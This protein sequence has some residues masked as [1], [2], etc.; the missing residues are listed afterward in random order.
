MEVQSAIP[1]LDEM[2]RLVIPKRMRRALRWQGGDPIMLSMASR[3]SLLLHRY[4]QMQALRAVASGYADAFFVTY[5]V[6][7]AICD[8]ERLLVHRGFALAGQPALSQEFRRWLET[9]EALSRSA[10]PLLQ[11]PDLQAGILAAIQPHTHTV[12]A[13]LL[14]RCEP[15]RPDALAD[16]AQ[17]LARMIAAQLQ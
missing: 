3:D 2:V 11:G 15:A 12:G 13:V 17:L 16:A 8:R 5:Q 1:R 14:G 6:P 9:D 7:V 4:P 10:L